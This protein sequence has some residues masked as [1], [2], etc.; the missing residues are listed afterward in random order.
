MNRFLDF[1]EIAL[2][3]TESF[4]LLLLKAGFIFV[5]GLFLAH[6]ARKKIAKVISKKDEILGNFTSQVASIAILII[7]IVTILANLGVQIGSILA[8]L[9]TAGVAIALALKDSL[10]SIAGGIILIVLRPFR[11]ND[12]I[13][14]GSIT[15]NVEGIN[16][17]NTMIRMP[18][19]KLAILP[20][21]NVVN[22]NIINC[23][24]SHKRRIEWVFGV[25]YD[26]DIEEIRNIIKDVIA[27]MDKVDLSIAPFIGVTDFGQNS[28]NFTIRI[29]AKL[30]DNVFG[31]RSEL[32]EN[33]KIALDKKNI[34]IPPQKL[35]IT[36]LSQIK[37]E[38]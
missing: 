20:N 2:P 14:L 11:K 35:D 13:E 4:F 33:T 26:N 38:K 9:G 16:L 15:G 31:I 23:T 8:V 37:D 34:Q 18:D 17:F 5:V 12:T 29:W 7:T 10:S 30:Q 36:I 27:K 25:K 19:D 28:L 6:F 32:I 1:L 21:R 24:D 3:F 22:A